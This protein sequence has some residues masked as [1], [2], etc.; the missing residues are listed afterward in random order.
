MTSFATL[1]PTPD[2]KTTTA[3]QVAGWYTAEAL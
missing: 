3:R 2:H 1:H